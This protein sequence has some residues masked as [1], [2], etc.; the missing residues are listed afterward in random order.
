VRDDPEVVSS[1]SVLVGCDG[2]V[3]RWCWVARH[4]G[5]RAP[6]RGAGGGVSGRARACAPRPT[7]ASGCGRLRSRATPLP[8]T[9]ARSTR[10]RDGGCGS[11]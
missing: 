8:V 5:R 1:W 7:A 11:W 2:A 9:G 4:V 6:A 3:T 10:W